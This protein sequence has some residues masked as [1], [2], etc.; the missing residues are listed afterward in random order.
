MKEQTLRDKLDEVS[1]L[2]KDMDEHYIQLASRQTKGYVSTVIM[3]Q[4]EYNKALIL[5]GKPN[6]TLAQGEAFR[7]RYFTGLEAY[8]IKEKEKELR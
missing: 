5:G 4:I 8:I 2:N 3:Y 6:I 1:F 7:I